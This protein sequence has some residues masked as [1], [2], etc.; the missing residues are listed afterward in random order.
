MTNF[1][2]LCFLFLI[3]F[4]AIVVLLCMS[5]SGKRRILAGLQS[6]RWAIVGGLFRFLAMAILVLIYV[7]SLWFLIFKNAPNL[8][9]DTQSILYFVAAGASFCVFFYSACYRLLFNKDSELP[10]TMHILLCQYNSLWSYEKSK[11]QTIKW[12]EGVHTE[13]KRFG[14]DNLIVKQKL[15]EMLYQENGHFWK[16]KVRELFGIRKKEI[17]VEPSDIQEVVTALLI[18]AGDKKVNDF[19]PVSATIVATK[20]SKKKKILHVTKK[21]PCDASENTRCSDDG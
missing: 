13:L 3:I 14:L 11:G 18:L 15:S 19:V 8:T 6:I 7:I 2:L 16:N 12:L 9:F 20:V 10:N 5:I 4:L 1:Q 17:I 21:R